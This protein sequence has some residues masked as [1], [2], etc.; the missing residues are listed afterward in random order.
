MCCVALSYTLILVCGLSDNLP[1]IV[2]CLALS[3]SNL[4]VNTVLEVL[5]GEGFV[6]TGICSSVVCF[7]SADV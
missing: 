1:N 7:V 4:E 2:K 5:G 3:L 6:V